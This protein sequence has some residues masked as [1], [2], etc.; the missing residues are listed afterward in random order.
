MVSTPTCSWTTTPVDAVMTATQTVYRTSQY[1]KIEMLHNAV[2]NSAMPRAPELDIQ[3]LYFDPIHRRT[4][5]TP[6]P[7]S[8]WPPH[9]RW[10]CCTS[11]GTS[12]PSTAL[13]PS[14]SSAKISAEAAIAAVRDMATGS[15]LDDAALAAF[16]D[17]NGGLL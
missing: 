4:S 11:S 8:A 16:L 6:S 14:P 15:A 7:R 12:T 13:R 3:Q 10:F 9:E 2:P 17:G 1:E 5:S